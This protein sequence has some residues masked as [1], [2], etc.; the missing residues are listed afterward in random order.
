[1]IVGFA[2]LI[3]TATQGRLVECNYHLDIECDIAMAIDLEVHPKI[4][5]AL[6]PAPG[7]PIYIFQ[8][9]GVKGESIVCEN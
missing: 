2:H 1:M 6:L 8:N 4:T 5:V 9:Y 3:Q 7:Q